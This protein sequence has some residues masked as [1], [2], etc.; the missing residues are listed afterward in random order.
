MNQNTQSVASYS[1]N[2][3]SFFDDDFAED[4]DLEAVTEI[5]R[6]K[7]QEAVQK[8]FE[9]ISDCRQM[10]SRETNEME[11]MADIDFECFENWWILYYN[12]E[13]ISFLI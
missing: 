3:D 13:D 9:S 1:N 4:I 10:A 5:E 6:Q 2:N 8:R 12:K 7:N 11:E